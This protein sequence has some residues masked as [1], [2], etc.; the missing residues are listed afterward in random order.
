VRGFSIPG[1]QMRGTWGT[2]SFVDL[3]R[4]KTCQHPITPCREK[5]FL[6]DAELFLY[7]SWAYEAGWMGGTASQR[8]SEFAVYSIFPICIECG[9]DRE[10]HAT[11]GQEAGVTGRGGWG[12]MLSQG[13][14]LPPHGRRP[15]HGGPGSG[16]FSRSPYKRIGKHNDA[17]KMS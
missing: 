16:L 11:A 2:R 17:A 7:S 13:F 1:P 5:R 9:V 4:W 14:S 10:V 12:W 15:V 6:V 3:R 8:V